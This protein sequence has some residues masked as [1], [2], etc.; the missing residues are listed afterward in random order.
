MRS[1]NT[2][3]SKLLRDT[4][5]IITT[6]ILSDRNSEDE[7]APLN[8]RVL[9]STR[10]SVWETCKDIWNEEIIT[11]A[12]WVYSINWYQFGLDIDRKLNK[13][14]DKVVLVAEKK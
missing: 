1:L 13:L 4:Q 2:V 10:P 11:A 14:T 8:R 12:N 6:R 3:N 7:L 5:D 9:W